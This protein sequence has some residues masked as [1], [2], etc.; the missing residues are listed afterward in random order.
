[1]MREALL[2]AAVLA[3][4]VCLAADRVDRVRAARQADVQALVKQAGLTY[5]VAEVYLRVFKA[6][7]EV[8]LWASGKVG[9]PMVL[10]KRYE[11]C[12]ASGGPGPKR[13]EGDLQVPEGLYEISQFNPASS[14]HLSL[15]VSYP[16]KSDRRR[17]DRAHPG[18][19]IYL[20]GR[21]AS[22]G[23]IAI[24]DAPIEEVYLISADARRQPVR[25]D[26][27]PARLTRAWLEAAPAE[28]RDFWAEL[29]P[30]FEGFEAARRPVP[31]T[32][33]P[34]T[35]AYRLAR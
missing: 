19:L 14:Y 7:R 4:T 27:F 21:C 23:C 6:E 2:V 26:L 25:I 31:V 9:Q 11:V 16:N 8:E 1:M 20:H 29:L 24:E 32:V 35:G 17:S 12:A 28:H 15:K 30:A 5:P 22:I 13:V 33:D 3:S 18:G 10:I 34:Q